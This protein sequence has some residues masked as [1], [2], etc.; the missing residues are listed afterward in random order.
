MVTHVL[1]SLKFIIIPFILGISIMYFSYQIFTLLVVLCTAN[2]FVSTRTISNRAVSQCECSGTYEQCLQLVQNF[3]EKFLY[4]LVPHRS[5][6]KTC[7]HGRREMNGNRIED[8][9][10][11]ADML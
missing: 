6:L 10:I 7:M 2:M 11:N 8:F 9:G 1:P 3:E 5:C 4:C